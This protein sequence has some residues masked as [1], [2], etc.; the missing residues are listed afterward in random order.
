MATSG[1]M[2]HPISVSIKPAA[3]HPHRAV[4]D[5]QAPFSQFSH[6]ST[7]GEVRLPVPLHSQSR[8]GLAIFFGL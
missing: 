4:I 7:Q 6:Q 5:L 8:C 3:A 1:L 2:K